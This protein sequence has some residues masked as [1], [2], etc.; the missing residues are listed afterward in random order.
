M[1]RARRRKRHATRQKDPA[2]VV[3]EKASHDAASVDEVNRLP[4][5]RGTFS[6]TLASGVLLWAAFPPLDLWPLAW[7]APLFWIILIRRDRLGGKRPYLAVWLGCTF[8]WLIMLYGIR[9]AHPVLNLGWVAMSAYLAAYPALFIGLTRV[10][11]H[12]LRIS[13]VL[14]APIVWTGMELARGHA[15]TGFSMALLG[16]TQVRWATLIQISDILGAYGV[17]F[18]VMLVAACIARMSPTVQRT[19]AGSE[20][21][22]TLWPLVPSVFAVAAVIGYGVYSQQDSSLPPTSEPVLRVALIQCSFDTSYESDPEKSE[23]M[24]EWCR[25]Q[26]LKAVKSHPDLDLVVWPESAFTG[27]WADVVVEGDLIP[28]DEVPLDIDEYQ[29][30]VGIWE[31]KF[32]LKTTRIATE[33]NAGRNDAPNANSRRVHLLAGTTTH[34][35]GPGETRRYNSALFIDP[36]GQV[37]RRYHK[38][39]LVPFGEYILLGDIF[40]WVYRLT[41]MPHGLDSGENPAAFELAGVRMAPSICFESTVPHLIRWQI[42]S[43]RQ[44]GKSPDVLVNITNDGWFRGASILDFQLAC[45]VFRAVE[46]RLPVLV[47]ANTGFSASIDADGRIVQQGPRRQG[48]VVYAEIHLDGRRSWYQSLGDLPAGVCLLFCVFT[49]GVGVVQRLRR[50]KGSKRTE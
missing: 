40:P 30:R 48:Q 37:V 31:E 1:N 14:A 39:H 12:R 24:Y 45:A 34:C 50:P 16:H 38:M 26:S 32:E 33:L 2:A 43:L 36:N 27:E 9:L 41:P 23:R 35:L 7:V 3:G 29:R 28:P 10:A 21:R 8:H 46:N 6:L 44:S 5:Y 13:I 25:E 18:L 49:G 42:A 4:W 17:S 11:V 47:A 15:I 19:S 20:P 22:L